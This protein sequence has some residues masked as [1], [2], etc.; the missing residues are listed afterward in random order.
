[1]LLPGHYIENTSTSQNLTWIEIYKSDRVADVSLT[2]GR[3]KYDHETL[4]MEASEKSSLLIAPQRKLTH[5]NFCHFS[6]RIFQRNVAISVTSLLTCESLRPLLEHH[7]ARTMFLSSL[8]Q[9]TL[10]EQE[11][12]RPKTGRYEALP[13]HVPP[14][15][16]NIQEKLLTQLSKA[17]QYK[18]YRADPYSLS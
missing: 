8:T 17:Y 7:V 10:N 13:R 12:I 11:S 16:A 15:S 2:G 1:M 6:Y 18:L 4:P 9:R 3:C 14:S 5:L